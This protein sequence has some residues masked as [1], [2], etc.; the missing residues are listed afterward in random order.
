MLCCLSQ[1]ESRVLKKE[2]L[3]AQVSDREVPQSTPDDLLAERMDAA[4][5]MVGNGEG[6]E[7][8]FRDWDM[9]GAPISSR[10]FVALLAQDGDDD[11]FSSD[12]PDEKLQAC[13]VSPT[14]PKP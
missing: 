3:L 4:Q 5:L 9:R 13:C 7:I 2:K 12:F 8:L 6:E 11:L 1:H 10:R 14:H